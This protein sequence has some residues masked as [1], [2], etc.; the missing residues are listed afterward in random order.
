M[1]REIVGIIDA[2]FFFFWKWEEKF[3]SKY[4]I[5]RKKRGRNPY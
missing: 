2:F 3:D 5:S 4:D 1:G